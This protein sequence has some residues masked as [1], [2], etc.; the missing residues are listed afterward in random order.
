[1][2]KERIRLCFGA[3]NGCLYCMVTLVWHV[4]LFLYTTWSFAFKHR[5][6]R[7]ET[8][9]NGALCSYWGESLLNDTRTRATKS[10]VVFIGV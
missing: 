1:M 6:S 2:L 7:K 5:V 3:S 8:S 9:S 10:S 4:N